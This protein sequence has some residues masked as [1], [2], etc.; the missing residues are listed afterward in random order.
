MI[1]NLD[2]MKPLII[3][4]ATPLIPPQVGGGALYAEVLSR[5][6]REAGHTVRVVPFG[7][8]LRFPT[9][10]RHI[11]YLF[12]LIPK[13]IHTDVVYVLDT[14]SVALPAVFLCHLL[15]K[16]VIVRVGGDFLW[17]TYIN[18]TR[19][20]ILLSEFY[21]VESA[22]KSA[23]Q[24]QFTFKENAIFDLT[25][26]IFQYASKIVFST[27]WQKDICTDVFK[28]DM[29]KVHVVQNIFA[30]RLKRNI[31]PKNRI[32]L[33][34]SRN[35]FLKN[36]VG[37]MQAFALVKDR[38]FE[39]ELDTETSTHEELLRRMSD[40]Y[41]VVVPSFSE[42][43]PNTV[44]DALSLGVPV[45]VTRDC[46]MKEHLEDLVVWVDPKS[47]EDIARGIETLMDAKVYSEYMTRMSI[48]SYTHTEEMYAKELLD[49]A[50]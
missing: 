41:M 35:I 26:F 3:T 9:G 45:V 38:Y 50:L 20:K 1:D 12:K 7:S 37:L 49:L 48:F 22:D 47:P 14:F 6:W 5:Q 25:N 32:I 44:L 30:E 31:V 17:E 27:G 39:A 29:E 11:L 46:G 42:V 10:L 8:L 40:A 13:I 43:S 34:P 23:K 33:S 18:R 24:R 21:P 19:E 36:K 4:I 16:K 15:K 2:T 28:L